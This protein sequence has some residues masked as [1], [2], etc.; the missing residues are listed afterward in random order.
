MDKGEQIG[1]VLRTRTNV[2][3]LYVSPGH[4]IGIDS[5]MKFAMACT[6]KYRL[7]ADAKRR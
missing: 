1:I 5:S 7:P 2:K 3:P 6:T 4:R